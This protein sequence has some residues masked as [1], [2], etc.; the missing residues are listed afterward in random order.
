[1]LAS[2]GF[3]ALG[4]MLRTQRREHRSNPVQVGIGAE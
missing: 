4:A 1:V 3:A 2:L